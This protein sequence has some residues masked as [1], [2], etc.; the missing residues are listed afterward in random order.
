[1]KEP[2]T[3][4]PILLGNPVLRNIS[5]LSLALALLYPLAASA[6]AIGVVQTDGTSS[7]SSRSHALT[8]AGSFL[9]G[10]SQLTFSW[11]AA[12]ADLAR[13]I[14]PWG[15]NRFDLCL[16]TDLPRPGEL[17]WES[18]GNANLG[19]RAHREA[20]ILEI[21]VIDRIA[22]SHVPVDAGAARRSSLQATQ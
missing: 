6:L 15:E 12:P 22:R 14:R 21:S 1:M 10:E 9:G 17:F 11:D 2:H 13:D 8:A 3:T 19:A 20:A 5:S 4:W 16:G 7:D 18:I